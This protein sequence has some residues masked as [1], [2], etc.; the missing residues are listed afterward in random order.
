ME[1]AFYA[2]SSYVTRVIPKIVQKEADLWK[3]ART[4]LLGLDLLAED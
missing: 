3:V 2:G 1:A 4:T